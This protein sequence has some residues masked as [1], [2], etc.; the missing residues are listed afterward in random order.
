MFFFSFYLAVIQPQ[1]FTSTHGD[2]SPDLTSTHGDYSPDFTSTHG[3]H[4]PAIE[5]LQ[6]RERGGYFATS[7]YVRNERPLYVRYRI[8]QVVK[9]RTLGYKGVIAGWDLQARVLDC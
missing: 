4:S 2:L 7:I 8:G 5:V 6:Y 3:D 1:D 9:H